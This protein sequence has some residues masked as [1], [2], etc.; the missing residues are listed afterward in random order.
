M[1]PRVLA[2]FAHPD[3][4]EFR[5][6]GT[7]LALGEVGYELHYATATSGDL[8]ALSGARAKI[9]ATRK[10]EAK[11]AAKLLGAKW[12][13]SFAEDMAV[14]YST[15]LLRRAAA[16]VRKVAPTILLTHPPVDYMED[17]TET[18]RLA[19]S[20]A[21]I[22]G[23]PLFRTSPP[24]AAI[25]GPIAVYHSTPHGLVGPLGELRPP[26]L[27]VDTAKGHAQKLAALAL[28][29][30]QREWLDATQGLGSYVETAD[31]E[32]RALAR[33]VPDIE[34]AEGWTQHHHLGFGPSGF[35]PLSDAL[36]ALI[37][38]VATE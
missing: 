27:L 3:D 32:S 25:E 2:L 22:R 26:A 29:T 19:V 28:H 23:A 16:L 8:G 15:R 9:A 21:F 6:A 34:H 33:L 30:S 10:A 36:G 13:G 7:M 18:C 38:R 35:D 4:V 17:H 12:H 31:V 37:H 14:I 11:A 20:A 24:R 5:A 1:K